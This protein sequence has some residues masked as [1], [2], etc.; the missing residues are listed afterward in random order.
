MSV[1]SWA[2]LLVLA[3]VATAG[4]DGME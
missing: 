2:G 4:L 3:P 1:L